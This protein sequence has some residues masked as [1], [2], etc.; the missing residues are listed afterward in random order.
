LKQKNFFKEV[1]SADLQKQLDQMT[2]EQIAQKAESMLPTA[3]QA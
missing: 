1:P 2:P 3:V